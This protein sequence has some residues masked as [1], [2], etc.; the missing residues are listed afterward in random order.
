MAS[1]RGLQQRLKDEIRKRQARPRPQAV[2]TGNVRR[3]RWEE[4]TR[5]YADVL[6]DIEATLVNCWREAPGLDDHGVHVAL[7]AAMRED[8]PDHPT[9]WYVQWALKA[10]RERRSD[11]APDVWLD[12]LR[13]VDQSV[14]DRSS[15]RQGDRSYLA[16]ILP[17][18][19][20]APGD[21]DAADDYQIIEARITPPQPPE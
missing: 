8:S 16:F 5:N 21:I 12:A 10:S 6:Q 4:I 11:V 19:A 15:L 7:V 20:A 13:V 9:A 18:V 14:R 2:A 3:D 1:K 17:Y